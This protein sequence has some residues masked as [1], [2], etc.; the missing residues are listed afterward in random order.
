LVVNQADIV[1]VLFALGLQP[2]SSVIVH[3]SLGSF[4]HVDGG[5][6]TVIEALMEVLTPR[7][8]LL[9]P[10]F[11]HGMIVEEG[12]SGCY[13]PLETPTINGAIP[14]T[15]RKLPGVYR[16]LDPTHPVAAWG[17]NAQRYTAFHHRTLTMSLDSPIG[18]LWKDGGYGLF[19]GVG[20]E[21]NTFHHVVETTTGA[22]CLGPRTEAYPVMLPGGRKVKGRTWGWRASPCPFTDEGR[23][24]LLFRQRKV[25]SEEQVGNSVATLFRLA[26]CFEVVAEILASGLDG[27]PPCLACPIRPR[28]VSN[29][30]PSDWD[31]ENNS[32]SPDSE[33]WT[34]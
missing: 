1:R 20:F 14:E 18:L 10:S 5:A 17:W 24:P 25:L 23:Y 11:N 2:G 15:F 28:I 31:E 32:L 16:S 3:S 8:T 26:D 33:A 19:L 27:Y 13:D 12:W 7:G 30:V 9:M 21:A 22:R 34:Y 4:G 29:T 6:Q